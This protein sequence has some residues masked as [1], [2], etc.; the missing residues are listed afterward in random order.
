MEKNSE[1]KKLSFMYCS[2][3]TS[4]MLGVYNSHLPL[5]RYVW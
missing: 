3:N 5:A 2:M 1:R 4:S